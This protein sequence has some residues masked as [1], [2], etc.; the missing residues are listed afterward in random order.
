VCQ[1]NQIR[2]DEAQ[3][4]IKKEDEVNSEANSEVMRRK[5]RRTMTLLIAAVAVVAAFVLPGGRNVAAAATTN[6]EASSGPPIKIGFVTSL[7]GPLSPGRA[8]AVAVAQARIKLANASG[9]IRGRKLVLV[10]AD[11]Q[12]TGP[13]ALTAAQY[14]VSQNVVGLA[15]GGSTFF[16]GP[17]EQYVS[18]RNIPMSEVAPDAITV[19]DSNVFSPLGSSGPSVPANTSLGKFLNTIKVT[20]MAGVALGVSAGAVALME[21]PLKA[22]V[23]LGVQTVLTDL[24]P[25][26]TTIDFTSDALKIKSSGAQ[27]VYTALAPTSNVALAT[28]LA[29]Q[30]VHLKGAVFSAA[31]Y[32]KT[33]LKDPNESAL[34]GS[35]VQSRF[36]PMELHNAATNAYAAALRKYAPGT[37]G[38][39]IETQSYLAVDLLVQGLQGVKGTPT[40]SSLKASLLRIKQYTGAGLIPEPINYTISKTSPSNLEKCYWYPQ[41][42]HKQWVVTDVAPVCGKISK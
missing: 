6:V 2:I 34:E 22:A 27:G 41:I 17:A 23:P 16:E 35:Y 39:Q 14:L 21:L 4:D 29:Q 28:A 13:G 1:N 30:G 26:P 24:T 42:K 25:T 31:G 36:A 15:L 8:A 37:F 32:E 5:S 33:V 40:P 11:D 20:K 9:G 7:T 3:P 18:S 19:A 12:S 10:V 38:G